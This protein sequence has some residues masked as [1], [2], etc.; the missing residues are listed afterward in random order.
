MGKW[1][2]KGGSLAFSG[3]ELLVS[4]D[5]LLQGVSPYLLCYL[6]FESRAVDSDVLRAEPLV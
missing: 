6:Y 2:D 1:I 4:K 3:Q 5:A